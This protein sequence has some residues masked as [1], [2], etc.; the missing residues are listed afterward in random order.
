M[1]YLHRRTLEH[2]AKKQLQKHCTCETR[3]AQQYCPMPASVGLTYG[4]FNSLREWPEDVEVAPLLNSTFVMVD[5]FALSRSVLRNLEK[6]KLAARVGRTK[7][8]LTEL[9]KLKRAE[10]LEVEHERV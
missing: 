3:K 9:G 7:C 6:S 2:M 4:Q 1:L 5:V 10:A 8:R